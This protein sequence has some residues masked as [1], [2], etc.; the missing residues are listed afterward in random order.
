MDRNEGL[1]TRVLNDPAVK[2]VVF[3]HIVERL[4]RELREAS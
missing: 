2:K 3:A 4:Y 1:V